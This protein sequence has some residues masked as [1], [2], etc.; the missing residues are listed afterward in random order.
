MRY[1]GHTMCFREIIPGIYPANV[2]GQ[3]IILDMFNNKFHLLSPAAS[4]KMLSVYCGADTASIFCAGRAIFTDTF[5]TEDRYHLLN[6]RAVLGMKANFW[7]F[8]A[9]DVLFKPYSGLW[10]MLICLHQAH[11]LVRRGWPATLD[12]LDRRWRKAGQKTADQR[13]EIV[14]MIRHLNAATLIYPRK[15]VCLAWS[16]A[17]LYAAL[18]NGFPLTLHIGVQNIPFYS[19]AWVAMAGQVLCDAPD[20]P[21]KMVTI[22]SRSWAAHV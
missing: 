16:V 17:L 1:C 3:I 2:R 21:Q 12:C 10:R 11:R 14:A 4:K 18:P 15:T 19:H 20:L 22:F 8:S 13:S 5:V 6:T 7:R 9:A